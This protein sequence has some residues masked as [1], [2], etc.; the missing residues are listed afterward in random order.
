MPR[1]VV[2][3]VRVTAPVTVPAGAA[4]APAQPQ[5]QP[6]DSYLTRLIKYI[7]AEIIAVYVLVE[8]FIGAAQPGGG[9]NSTGQISLTPQQQFLVFGAFLIATP[10]YTAIATKMAWSQVIISTVSFAAWAFALGGPFLNLNSYKN[11]PLIA[12]IVLPVVVL[13]AGI[14]VPKPQPV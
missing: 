6:G 8:G 9:G 12:A 3:P 11:E 10:I 14:V 2:A 5:A 1:R 13:L 7:P 4:P